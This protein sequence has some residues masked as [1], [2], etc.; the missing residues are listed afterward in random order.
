MK[1]VRYLPNNPVLTFELRH[2]M[3]GHGN[4]SHASPPPQK[5]DL[6]IVRYFHLFIV[7]FNQVNFHQHDNVL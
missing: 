7:C 5:K 1:R 4:E 6:I 2:D 3:T